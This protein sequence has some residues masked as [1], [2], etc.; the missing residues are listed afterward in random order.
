MWYRKLHRLVGDTLCAIRKKKYDED[1][2][3][4]PTF[5]E[6]H[7]DEWETLFFLRF[8]SERSINVY[9]LLLDYLL[10]EE[11]FRSSGLAHASSH[12]RINACGF[13]CRCCCYFDF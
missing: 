12:P 9:V 6:E 1:E 2:V 7:T 8:D 5:N 3:I 10:K 11:L 4:I 13:S